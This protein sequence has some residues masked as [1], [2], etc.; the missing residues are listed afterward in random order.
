MMVAG[1]APPDLALPAPATVPTMYFIGVTTGQSSIM[2]VFPRWA[3][4]LGLGP[5]VMR[6]IDLP[7]GAPAAAYRAAVDFI[8]HDPLSLGALV[9]THKIDLL[10]AARD[11]FDGLDPHAERLHEVSCL[12]KRDG[13]LLGHAKDPISAG[14]ALDGLVPGG[15]FAAAGAACLCLGAGGAGTALTWH[16]LRPERGPDRP[17][18]LVVADTRRERLE[19][20]RRVHA[21]A[22][23]MVETVHVTGGDDCDRLMAALP[24][25]SLVVNATGL[26]KDRPGSPISDAAPFPEHGYVWELNYRGAL[27]F[28][29]Q[30]RRQ[31]ASRTLTIADGWTYF[32]H[33]W[34]R[35]IAEVFAIDIPTR[36]PGFEALSAL[37]RAPG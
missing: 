18:R 6:G 35:A 14:L 12:S 28:L 15:H 26:G 7:L 4:H 16:L 2:S 11:L 1:D 30:A 21:G 37:A 27:V 3:A 8:R 31:Q 36:G 5:A 23:I 34:Q 17:S 20:L 24:P 10:R 9:T 19:E 22:E 33:G 13:R 25:G 32:L 29:D